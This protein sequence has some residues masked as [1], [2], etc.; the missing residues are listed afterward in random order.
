MTAASVGTN[1]DGGTGW[2]E[3]AL[4]YPGESTLNW[5][6][7]RNINVVDTDNFAPEAFTSQREVRMKFGTYLGV[8]SSYHY[9]EVSVM[10][11]WESGSWAGR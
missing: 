8:E 10:N 2:L 4:V 6:G 1:N 3:A 7:W 9:S 5:V 11:V